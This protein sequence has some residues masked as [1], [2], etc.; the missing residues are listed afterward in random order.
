M[1]KNFI[2]LMQLAVGLVV[3]LGVLKA[4]DQ[5]EASIKRRAVLEFCETRSIKECW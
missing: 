4:C 5:H 3:L 2:D 1:S